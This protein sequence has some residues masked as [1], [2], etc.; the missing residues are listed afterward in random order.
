MELNYEHRVIQSFFN[1]LY[2][3][4]VHFVQDILSISN[5]FSSFDTLSFQILLIIYGEM[6]KT[7][8][9]IWPLSTNRK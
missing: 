2:F 6:T 9:G 3:L 8:V 1:S 5:V 7:P 4:Q